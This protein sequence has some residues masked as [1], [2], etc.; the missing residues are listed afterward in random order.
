MNLNVISDRDILS[1]TEEDR[2]FSENT[3]SLPFSH[4]IRV[5]FEDIPNKLFLRDE[6]VVLK[7]G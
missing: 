4:P 6:F 2:E 5:R 3:K 1:K 7:I